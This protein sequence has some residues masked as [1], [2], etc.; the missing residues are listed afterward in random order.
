MLIY[1]QRNFD[2]HLTQLNCAIAN[3][4]TI[5]RI[6]CRPI[7]ML[8]AFATGRLLILIPE[9]PLSGNIAL[10]KLSVNLLY[11]LKCFLNLYSVFQGGLSPFILQYEL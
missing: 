4:A 10:W 8:L 6:I 1:D 3:W 7:Q 2:L 5:M 9:V 11:M